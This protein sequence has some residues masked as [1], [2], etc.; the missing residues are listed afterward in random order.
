MTIFVKDDTISLLQIWV[1]GI[2]RILQYLF[3]IF[4]INDGFHKTQPK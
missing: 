4:P 3:S 2:L 1:E